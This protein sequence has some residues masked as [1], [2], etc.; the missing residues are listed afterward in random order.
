[1]GK[2]S[3]RVDPSAPASL[4]GEVA[5]GASCPAE[6]ALS[7]I[8]TAVEGI[9]LNTRRG[10]DQTLTSGALKLQHFRLPR[11]GL[12]HQCVPLVSDVKFVRRRGPSTWR[13]HSGAASCSSRNLKSYAVKSMPP[14]S[15]RTGRRREFFLFLGQLSSGKHN[16]A[17][18]CE[19][20]PSEP[21]LGTSKTGRRRVVWY[22]RMPADTLLRVSALS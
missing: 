8:Y 1:M 13:A 10:T 3:M 4:F 17:F 20:S 21:F 15:R 19:P 5:F 18:P 16:N 9:M 12:G 11:S 2:A 7:S 22:N 6:R 14:V